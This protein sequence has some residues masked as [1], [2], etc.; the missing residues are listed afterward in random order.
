[1]P[2]QAAV[3]GNTT[4]IVVISDQFLSHAHC[5]E[6]HAEN[7]RDAGARLAIVR[8]TVDFIDDALHLQTVV[9]DGAYHAVR[10]VESVDVGDFRRIEIVDA[11]AGGTIHQI[12][13][14]MLVLPR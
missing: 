4:T 7:F 6:I 14:W 13:G 1:L 8:K 3:I 12:V 9:L 5:L 2:V 10:V 11:G